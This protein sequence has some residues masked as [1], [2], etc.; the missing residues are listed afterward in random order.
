MTRSVQITTRV[1]EATAQRLTLL[2]QVTGRTKARLHYE[3]LIA[4]IE[5]ELAFIEAVEKG[6]EQAR[7]G[8]GRSLDEVDADLKRIIARYQTA[9]S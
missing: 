4:Y 2:A 6:R 5:Q 9:H 8:L 3:A 1:D 7:A